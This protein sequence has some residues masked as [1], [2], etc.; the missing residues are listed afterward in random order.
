MFDI[1]LRTYGTLPRL[2]KRRN[3]SPGSFFCQ[4]NNSGRRQHRQLSASYSLRS[5]FLCDNQ[6]SVSF[7]SCS[8]H[9]ILRSGAAEAAPCFFCLLLYQSIAGSAILRHFPFSGN[10]KSASL[11]ISFDHSDRLMWYSP[12]LPLHLQLKMQGGMKYW[13]LLSAIPK[14]M[15]QKGV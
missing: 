8:K 5:Q 1:Q 15:L 14:R 6:F 2:Q 13:Y 10:L 9:N 12:R 7:N 11:I 4:R 3:A